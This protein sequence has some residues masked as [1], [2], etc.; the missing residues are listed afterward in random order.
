MLGV[1][2]VETEPDCGAVISVYT[3][4]QAIEDG[5]LVDVS[6]V[7]REAGFKVPV[8]VTN[9]VWEDCCEWDERDAKRHYQD[10]SGRLWDVVSLA[11]WAIRRMP[12]S[13]GS[14]PLFYRI[15]RI[16]RVGCGRKRNVILKL[17]S[18]P[19]DNGEHVITIMQ[20][21]ED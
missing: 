1:Q 3:R 7:A 20:P 4:A 18:G 11:F 8:A 13:A 19:G 10:V 6:E 21:H 5:V 9:A 2:Q 15:S 12:E 14:E 16:P 17:V